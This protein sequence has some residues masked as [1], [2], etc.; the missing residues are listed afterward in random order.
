M[1]GS[2]ADA[3]SGDR[4]E[5]GTGAMNR[6]ICRVGTPERHD[7][8]GRDAPRRKCG[9]QRRDTL[10]RQSIALAGIRRLGIA[11]DDHHLDRPF[12]MG[13]DDAIN[14]R[15]RGTGELS[16]TDVERQLN[17]AIAGCP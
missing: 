13:H 12:R 9:D 5:A 10:V 2:A 14:Q 11:G 16:R 3:Q 4:L 15:Q 1:R 6:G 7:G 17:D 8:S